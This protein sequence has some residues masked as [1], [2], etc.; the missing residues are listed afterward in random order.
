[1]RKCHARK[2]RCAQVSCPEMTCAELLARK[3]RCENIMRGNIGEPAISTNQTMINNNRE[4]F[5]NINCYERMSLN[6]IRRNKLELPVCY[7]LSSR[8]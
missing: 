1:M 8:S 7:I 2:C 4:F 6:T 3:C 5:L